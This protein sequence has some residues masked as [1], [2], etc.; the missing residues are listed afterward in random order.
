ML[1]FDEKIMQVK[2]YEEFLCFVNLLFEKYPDLE[3]I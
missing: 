2:F 3:F 1:I